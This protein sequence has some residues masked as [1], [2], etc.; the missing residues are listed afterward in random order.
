MKKQL[1]ETQ[2]KDTTKFLMRSLKKSKNKLNKEDLSSDSLSSNS[3]YTF[4]SSGED[5]GKDSDDNSETESS[6]RDEVPSELDYES[7][8]FHY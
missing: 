7:M 4:S 5:K 2:K 3:G 8:P 1:Q 6:E